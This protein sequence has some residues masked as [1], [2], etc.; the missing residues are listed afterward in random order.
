[1][2]HPATIVFTDLDGTLLD[3]DSYSAAA[4]ASALARLRRANIPVILASSKT[5]AEMIEI[6][7]TLGLTSF[8]AIVENGAGLLPAGVKT[9]GVSSDYE[10]LRRILAEIDPDLR[11][12][13]VGFGDWNADEIAAQTG[14]ALTQAAMAGQRQYSEP[15]LWHGSDDD[16]ARFLSALSAHGVTARQGGRYLTLSFGASKADQMAAI[17]DQYG[18]QRSIAL[19]DAP[20]DIEMLQAADIAVVIANP[21]RAPLPPLLGE[22]DTTVL[23]PTAAGPAGWNAA[24]HQILDA[25]GPST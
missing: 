19:G 21:H 15:G 20:N 1:M 18:A 23:R 13:F 24:I 11:G 4:A 2:P 5:A 6:R 17:C 9:L 3:H 8:P 10:N 22:P 12:G 7:D 14:L 16:L 25:D